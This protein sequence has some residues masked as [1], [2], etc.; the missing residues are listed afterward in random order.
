MMIEQEKEK[1]DDD[2]EPTHAPEATEMTDTVAENIPNYMTEESR[3]AGS[4]LEEDVC[5]EMGESGCGGDSDMEADD[6]GVVLLGHNRLCND[7]FVLILEVIS[8]RYARASTCMY[9]CTTAL[10]LKENPWC[11]RIR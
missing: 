7:G 10:C 3:G 5:E 4:I 1:S 11:I 6:A 8:L 2:R 9:I